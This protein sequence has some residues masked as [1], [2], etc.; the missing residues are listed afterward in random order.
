MPAQYFRA[1][2]R[3]TAGGTGTLIVNVLHYELDSLT[4][5]VSFADVAAD[6][7]GHLQAP[8]L[9]L[10]SSDNTLNDITCTVE[11]YVGAVPAQ[12][13]HT[14]NLPGTR[15]PGDHHCS[16]ALCG[17]ARWVTAT[18]KRYARGHMFCPPVENSTDLGINNGFNTAGGAYWAAMNAFAT[19]YS[20]AFTVGNSTYSP[21]IFSRTRG[22]PAANLVPYVFPI[23]AVQVPNVQHFL[24]SRLSSP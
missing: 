22:K 24:R 13:L 21:I 5:G 12:G 10:L 14:V 17:I 16:T 3:S 20:Q 1:A 6:V 23:V 2:F 4:S 8:Y 18:P 19:A 15:T 7:A 11:D 9:A